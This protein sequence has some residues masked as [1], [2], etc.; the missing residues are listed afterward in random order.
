M[1]YAARVK[2]LRNLQ[3]VRLHFCILI[4]FK[5]GTGQVVRFV[6]YTGRSTI[7]PIISVPAINLVPLRKRA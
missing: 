4:T 1:S 7:N 5:S 3:R 2:R 6:I